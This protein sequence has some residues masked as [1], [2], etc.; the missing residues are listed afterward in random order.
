MLF[1]KKKIFFTIKRP[2]WA[3]N[4]LYKYN[5]QKSQRGNMARRFK[6]QP[7]HTINNAKQSHCNKII[8]IK[9]RVSGII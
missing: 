6:T 2:A 4:L 5:P 7:T 1:K 8:L 9:F 3:K